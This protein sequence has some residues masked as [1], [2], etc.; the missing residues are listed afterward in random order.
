MQYEKKTKKK[1]KRTELMESHKQNQR[2][3]L[4]YRKAKRERN[5]EI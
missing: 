5:R 4:S 3:D 1:K 2:I